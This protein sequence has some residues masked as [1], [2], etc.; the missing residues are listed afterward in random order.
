LLSFGATDTYFVLMISVFFIVH[1]KLI[2]GSY[3]SSREFLV[4]LRAAMKKKSRCAALTRLLHERRE[5]CD[6]VTAPE[7]EEVCSLT[8]TAPLSVH[9]IVAHSEVICVFVMFICF[10]S[11]T[12]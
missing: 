6:L 5:I 1:S 10:P 12:H 9:L 2:I 4:R 7:I 3:H 8:P 11:H